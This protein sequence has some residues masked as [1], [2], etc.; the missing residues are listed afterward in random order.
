M[1]ADQ[2][3]QKK[4]K[5]LFRDDICV[6]LSLSVVPDPHGQSGIVFRRPLSPTLRCEHERC[7]PSIVRC[8]PSMG[9]SLGMEIT[10]PIGRQLILSRVTENTDNRHNIPTSCILR[11]LAQN[12]I[13][14]TF[15]E[16][17]LAEQGS[18]TSKARRI[19]F[20]NQV[21]TVCR[22]RFGRDRCRWQP[23]SALVG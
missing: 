11:R 23:E 20:G 14:Q 18:R 13:W 16:S 1:N 6:H 9:L 8:Q 17:V 7:Q 21:S 15:R 5:F 2:H 19:C 22:D 3:R 12:G 4:T 10:G